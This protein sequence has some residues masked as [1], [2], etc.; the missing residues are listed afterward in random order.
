MDFFIFV[1]NQIDMIYL[2]ELWEFLKIN[3]SN[4]LLLAVAGYFIQR[5][6][7]L[8]DE[9]K[10]EKNKFFA[11]NFNKRCNNLFE[12]LADT[13]NKFQLNQNDL[14]TTSTKIKE[15][16]KKN[17]LYLPEEIIKICHDYSDY[18]L[19]ISLNS[20]NRDLIFEDS[21]LKKFKIEF[22]K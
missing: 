8:K 20:R 19:E 10:S 21:L 9:L 1:I 12:L 3:F 4:T 5:N 18:L 22:K 16:T 11:E 13:R 14:I 6:H 15:L 7:K 17:Y 2:T